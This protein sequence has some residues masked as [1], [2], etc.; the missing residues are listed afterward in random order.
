MTTTAAEPERQGGKTTPR[1]D[2][3]KMNKSTQEEILTT[4]CNALAILDTCTTSNPQADIFGDTPE[5]LA[6]AITTLQEYFKTI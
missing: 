5:R 2:G 4:L 1:K 6:A 3:K